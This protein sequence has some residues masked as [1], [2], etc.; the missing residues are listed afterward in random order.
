MIDNIT[1]WVVFAGIVTMPFAVIWFAVAQNTEAVLITSTIY[2]LFVM[3][4]I[5]S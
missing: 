3:K 2:L 1:R 4:W 5:F